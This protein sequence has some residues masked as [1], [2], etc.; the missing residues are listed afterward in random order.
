MNNHK[1]SASLFK[2]LESSSSF[3]VIKVG[4]N[5]CYSYVNQTFADKFSFIAPNLVGMPYEI[6]IHPEDLPVCQEATFACMSHPEKSVPVKM[7]KPAPGGEYFWAFYEFSA[8]LA[9]DGAVAE[10]LCIGYDITSTEK[11]SER[12]K[13]EKERL[14]VIIENMVDGFY[15]LDRDWRFI[16]ANQAFEDMIGVLRSR[17]VGKKIWDVLPKEGYQNNYKELYNKAI[18]EGQTINFEEYRPDLKKWFEKTVYPS[19]EGLTVILKD[20]TEHKYTEEKIQ[21]ANSKLIAALNST[22]DLNI[23]ISPDF[24]VSSF[25]KVAAEYARTFFNQ[26]ITEG[27]SFWQLIPPGTEEMFRKNVK[28]AFAGEPIE[29]KHQFNFAPGVSLWYRIR[30][31][32]VRNAESALIGV[33]FNAINIDKEQR[34][35]ANL[36]E[37]ASLYSR[38]VKRPVATIVGITH[39]INEDDLNPANKEWFGYLIKTTQELDRVINRIMKKSNEL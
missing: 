1:L 10:I 15:I 24:T 38:E 25:N 6:T 3:Y 18:Q 26:T 14:D 13:R 8:V 16:K 35:L 21:E 19:Q 5:G 31:Y 11:A 29:Q 12:A 28:L 2:L 22:S 27:D 33:A 37:I 4:M 34:Q 9:S 7:R 30:F 17:F 23:L 20:I 32:P 36:E 39:L